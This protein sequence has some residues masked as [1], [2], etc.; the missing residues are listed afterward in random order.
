MEGE[1]P[2]KTM[3]LEKDT[4]RRET[5]KIVMDMLYKADINDYISKIIKFEQNLCKYHTVIW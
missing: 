5:D 3:S 4:N 2:T 1:I